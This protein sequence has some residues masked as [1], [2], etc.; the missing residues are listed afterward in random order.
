MQ[1]ILSTKKYT[2]IHKAITGVIASGLIASLATTPVMAYEQS[3]VLGQSVQ[4][5]QQA[6]QKEQL[7]FGSGALIG[8]VV[9]GP[10]GAF[11][12]G[13]A[14][15]LWA[16]HD[17]TV[18]QR[19][20]LSAALRAQKQHHQQLIKRQQ[21]TLKQK[22]RSHRSEL[23]ALQQ[24]QQHNA[25]LLAENLLMSLQ[26]ATGSSEL[27]PHYQSQISALAQSLS[28][29]PNISIDLS[30]YTDLQGSENRNQQ[31]SLARVE[32]VKQALVAQGIKPER[33]QL[34]A[35]GEQQPIA[36]NAQQPVNFY[37][38]RVDI[39]LRVYDQQVVK[40]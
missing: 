6:E 7:A 9:A 38:R 29:Y 24:N 26:F 33:I 5:Q 15:A 13:L 1:S 34:Y 17:N 23:L 3:P 11:F 21:L 14:A 12:T 27:P 20:Q 40:N 22:E 32:S 30:G 35:F 8:A 39:N 28:Q 36:A 18:D 4:Q 19:D 37:D 2:L 16:K 10:F 25:S 31:L